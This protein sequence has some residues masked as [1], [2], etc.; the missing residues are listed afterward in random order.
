MRW[1]TRRPGVPTTIC[2]PDFSERICAPMSIPPTQTAIRTPICAS[3]QVS[4]PATCEASSRVGAT[5]SARGDFAGG[6]DPSP[7]KSS[8]AI[9][10]PNA[11]VL[12]DPVR[13]E[14]RRSRPASAVAR[15]ASW[16]GVALW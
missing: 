12:P 9:S 7:F 10:M 15:T 16:T 8:R 14:T 5:T 11:M 1:S 6:R 13:E 3:S 4:S 2:A